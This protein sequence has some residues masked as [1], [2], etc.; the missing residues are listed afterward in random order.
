MT[1]TAIIHARLLANRGNWVPMT[2]LALEAGCYA[3]NS[4]VADIRRMFGAI[5]ENSTKKVN[6]KRHSYYRIP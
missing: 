4:R 5:V 3:V 2:E 1:Q 6:G